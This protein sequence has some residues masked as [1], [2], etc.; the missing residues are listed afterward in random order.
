MTTT[1]ITAPE[2]G[3]TSVLS[4]RSRELRRSRKDLVALEAVASAPRRNDL[5]PKIRLEQRAVS[6][7]HAPKRALRQVR[8]DHVAEIARSMSMFGLVEPLLITV[9]GTIIDGVSS[10]RAAETI[11]LGRPK[12]R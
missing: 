8:S 1:Q 4:A 10:A 7:L 11:G 9:D 5:L 12:E 6:S 3:L 2:M